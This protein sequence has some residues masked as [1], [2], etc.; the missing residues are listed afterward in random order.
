MREFAGIVE[1]PVL[2]SNCW[3]FA[4]M[5]AP[6]REAP[7]ACATPVPPLCRAQI[8]NRRLQL[9]NE[10]LKSFS[11]VT[12]GREYLCASYVRDVMPARLAR[13]DHRLA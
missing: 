11:W 2:G 12:N 5:R 9:G 1:F 3:H 6:D 10:K 8:T 13:Y 4:P 7:G